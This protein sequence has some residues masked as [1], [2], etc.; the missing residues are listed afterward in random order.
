VPEGFYHLKVEAP[1]Y[2]VYEGK[3][4]QVKEGSGVHFNIELKTKFWWL[5]VVD[6][7][8]IVMIV[9]GILLLYNFYRDKIREKLLRKSH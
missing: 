9:F 5:K 7:K 2:L 8:I 6:W 4:F 3:S 1:S